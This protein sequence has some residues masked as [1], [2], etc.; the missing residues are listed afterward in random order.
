MSYLKINKFILIPLFLI[1]VI[2]LSGCYTLIGYPPE[3]N[4]MLEKRDADQKRVYQDYDY[5]DGLYDIRYI[6]VYDLYYF[7]NPFYY[8]R[9]WYNPWW[10]NDWYYWRN[11]GYYKD[12]PEIKKRDSSDFGRPERSNQL[13]DENK[14]KSNESSE[15]QKRNDDQKDK[16]SPR[17]ERNQE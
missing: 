15:N 14:D 13:Q 16:K 6:D 9:Y 4:E 5:Y 2:M 1:L 11:D 7:S 8:G 3:A 12:L 10:Y 17:R